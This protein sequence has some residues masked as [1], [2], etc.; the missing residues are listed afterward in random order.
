MR[1]DFR[2]LGLTRLAQLQIASVHPKWLSD[3]INDIRT[4]AAS[5]KITLGGTVPLPTRKHRYPV[6]ISPFI[7]KKTWHL[8]LWIK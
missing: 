3:C 8:F 1:W 2:K 5:M 6:R 4:S 7:H